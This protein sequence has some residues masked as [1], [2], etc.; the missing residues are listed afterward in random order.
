MT[1]GSW[2]AAFKLKPPGG[3]GIGPN[4]RLPGVQPAQSSPCDRKVQGLYQ[5]PASPDFPA[6]AQQPRVQSKEGRSHLGQ[7]ITLTLALI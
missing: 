4:L 3:G 2:Y 1:N 7:S 5:N 6:P